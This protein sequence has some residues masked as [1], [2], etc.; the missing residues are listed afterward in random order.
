MHSTQ[1]KL[2]EIFKN[3]FIELKEKSD[4][5]IIASTRGEIISWDSASHFILITCIEEE[6]SITVSDEL[7]VS[8]NSFLDAYRIVE[9]IKN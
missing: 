2:I 4:E 8:M 7:I 1:N 5:W 9:E 6:F 3:T